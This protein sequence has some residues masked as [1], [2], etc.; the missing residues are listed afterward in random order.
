M[1]VLSI[2]LIIAAA[3]VFLAGRLLEQ[4]QARAV[5]K[6]SERLCEESQRSEMDHDRETGDETAQKEWDALWDEAD[7]AIDE[8]FYRLLNTMSGVFRGI[9]FVLFM[10]ALGLIAVFWLL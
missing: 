7:E 1:I 6:L 10:I 5:K 3:G 4:Y 9:A 2:L 8:D